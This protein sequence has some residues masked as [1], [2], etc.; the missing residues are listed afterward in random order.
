MKYIKIKLDGIESKKINYYRN[1]DEIIMSLKFK[2]INNVNKD[3]ENFL[4]ELK[5]PESEKLK[6]DVPFD[7]KILPEEW[8]KNIESKNYLISFFITKEYVHMNIIT[9]YMNKENLM[10]HIKDFF[11]IV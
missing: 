11:L 3:I 7:D 9:F 5:F 10:K 6:I 2:K 1:N 8:I 4:S